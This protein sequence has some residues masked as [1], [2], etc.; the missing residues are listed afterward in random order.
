MFLLCFLKVPAIT[1]E[2]SCDLC[3][4]YGVTKC[5]NY[6]HG[7]RKYFMSEHL[8]GF[9]MLSCHHF[10]WNPSK[11]NFSWFSKSPSIR[12]THKHTAPL[13]R[14]HHFLLFPLDTS[15]CFSYI[16]FLTSF[17]PS[18][19]HHLLQVNTLQTL[20]RL[21]SNY[22]RPSNVCSNFPFARQ[23][24]KISWKTKSA[25]HFWHGFFESTKE[26][27]KRRQTSCPRNMGV[28]PRHLSWKRW[29]CQA[30]AWEFWEE[31]MTGP[32][33][34][35][36]TTKKNMF[37]MDFTACKNMTLQ[38]LPHLTFEVLFRLPLLLAQK[39]CSLKLRRCCGNFAC[40]ILKA[41]HFDIL[42][43]FARLVY[44]PFLPLLL[45]HE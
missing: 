11:P 4:K 14:W 9:R 26:E 20:F 30:A 42:Y 17:F 27:D 3:H 38:L 12:N 1:L 36:T 37:S 40:L 7:C 43:V 15:T 31:N 21:G 35:H 22:S 33:T 29:S 28:Y 19:K 39:S 5:A 13:T 18:Q 25:A 6:W 32:S 41:S 10:K 34:T 2:R 23:P 16:L 45:T 24:E 8:Q 44:K